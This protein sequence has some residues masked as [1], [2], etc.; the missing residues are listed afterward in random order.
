MKTILRNSIFH[1]IQ[2]KKKPEKQTKTKPCVNSHQASEKNVLIKLL[3]I[4][5]R[6]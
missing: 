2:N 3:E 1:S 6:V 4:E 5:E